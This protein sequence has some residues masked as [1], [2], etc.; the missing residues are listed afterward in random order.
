MTD[1][2]KI[3]KFALISHKEKLEKLLSGADD[4][5]QKSEIVDIIGKDLN[6][7]I[8]LINIIKI[9]DERQNIRD[10]IDRLLSDPVQNSLLGKIKKFCKNG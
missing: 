9:D 5:E 10:D 3:L 1:L 6:R 4:A 7:T 8:H 2:A